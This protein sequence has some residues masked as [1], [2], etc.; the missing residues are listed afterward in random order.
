MPS[1]ALM[2]AEPVTVLETGPYDKLVLRSRGDTLDVDHIISRGALNIL[3]KNKNPR[4]TLKQI[5]QMSDRGPAIVIP[6]E[7]HK[8]YSETYKGRNTQ[9]RREADARNPEAAINSD[10]D[11]LM[12]GL[13][14][15]GLTEHE[16]QEARKQLLEN[17]KSGGWK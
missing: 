10:L 8:R 5:K 2:F 1:T 13:L 12:P 9:E 3:I 6:A 11:A 14:E 16:I 4:L 17:F 15:W 7:L